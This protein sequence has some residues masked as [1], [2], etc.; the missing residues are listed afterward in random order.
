MIKNSKDTAD[1]HQPTERRAWKSM[2]WRCVLIYRVW[3][4]VTSDFLHSKMTMKGKCFESFQDIQAVQLKILRNTDSR[5]VSDSGVNS[6][7]NMFAVSR[8]IS[9]ELVTVFFTGICV[10]KCELSSKF[11]IAFLHG[12]APGHGRQVSQN[13]LPTGG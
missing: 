11:L 2:A 5:A 1:K 9:R 3:Y 10:L 7:I 12:A 8:R 4:W 6:G 13:G